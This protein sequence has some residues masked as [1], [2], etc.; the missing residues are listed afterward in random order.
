M[1]DKEKAFQFFAK[2]KK[3]EIF[4]CPDTDFYNTDFYNTDFYNTDLL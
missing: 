2:N 4:V 1:L 3:I